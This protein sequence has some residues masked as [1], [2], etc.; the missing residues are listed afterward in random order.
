MVDK[1]TTDE[2]LRDMQIDL[3][4]MKTKLD[5]ITFFMQKIDKDGL[6]VKV[7]K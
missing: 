5:Y 7:I 6:K 2:R 3:R 1:I 4:H